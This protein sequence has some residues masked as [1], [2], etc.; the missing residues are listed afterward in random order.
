MIAMMFLV[1]ERLLLQKE[2][3]PLSLADLVLAIDQLLPR[4]E[5]TPEQLAK[6]I[7][8]RHRRRAATACCRRRGA[9]M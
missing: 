1:E 8:E 2:A 7:D 9:K 4:P 3:P 5:P 6:V